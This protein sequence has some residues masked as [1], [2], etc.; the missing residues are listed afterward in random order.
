VPGTS[1]ALVA[2]LPLGAQARAG[3]SLELGFDPAQVR[4]FAPDGLA[5]S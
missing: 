4:W 1:L 2:R 5:L 3:H